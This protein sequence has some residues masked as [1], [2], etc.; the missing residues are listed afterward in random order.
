MK[1]SVFENEFITSFVDKEKHLYGY[2]WKSTNRTMTPEQ[3]KEEITRQANNVLQYKPLFVLVDFRDSDFVIDTDLQGFV[4][5]TL[6][7][8]MTQVGAKKLAVI[9]TEDYIMQ[10]SIE[11]TV[12]EQVNVKYVTRYF[13][14]QDEAEQWFEDESE[15]N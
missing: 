8:N 6:F 1:E 14:S 11:Q 5:Q 2:R 15:G 12:N 9:Q 4:S 7:Q 10:L 13:S 3:Y